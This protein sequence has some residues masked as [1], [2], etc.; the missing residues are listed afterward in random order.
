[1]RCSYYPP[2]SCANP[3]SESGDRELDFWG[4]DP[5][6]LFIPSRPGVTG[7]IGALDR[8]DRCK[9]L[10]GF[11]SSDLPD[12]CVFWLCCCWS[13]LG[14]FGVVLLGFEKDSSFLQVVFWGCLCS[15]A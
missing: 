11:A 14:R 3:W 7:L 13:V 8:S 9:P 15:R 1:M 4:L 12:P 5:R 10:M 6:V 2:K